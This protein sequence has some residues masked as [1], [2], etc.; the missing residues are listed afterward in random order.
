MKKSSIDSL[1]I[2]VVENLDKQLLVARPHSPDSHNH[3]VFE[4][5]GGLEVFDINHD[6]CPEVWWIWGK[7]RD[8]PPLQ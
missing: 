1:W 8:H 6:T 2:E 5:F 7:R 4:S 3:A